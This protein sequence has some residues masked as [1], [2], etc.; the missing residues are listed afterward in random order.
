MAEERDLELLDDYL[1]NR[2]NPADKA[3]VEQRLKQDPD[4]QR[5]YTVQQNIAEGLRSARKAELKAMLNAVP[6][7][8]GGTSLVTKL[9]GAGTVALII[10]VGVYLYNDKATPAPEEKSLPPVTTTD[11]K[12]VEQ[13][14]TIAN[15]T[16]RA[17]E[18]STTVT[19]AP[20]TRTTVKPAPA[21]KEKPETSRVP[22]V[23]DPTAEIAEGG[24]DTEQTESQE[25]EVEIPKSEIVSEIITSDSKYQ[26]HY[27]R[28]GD[29]VTLYGPL[30]KNLFT[31]MDFNDVSTGKRS[32]FLYYKN[33]YYLLNENNGVKPLSPVNDPVLLKKLRE[34]K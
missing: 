8:T 9:V 16:P 11:D 22:Q 31:I 27:Q 5:E 12:P 2:L 10:G 14:E 24:D 20:S 3:Y 7:P 18:S 32:V 13:H 4:L 21:T 15:E 26:F 19:P 29:Q 6:I 33:N 17:E 34:S 23:Y 28:T 25:G 30:D 1:T